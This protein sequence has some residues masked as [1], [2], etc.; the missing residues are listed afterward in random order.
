MQ[1]HD[2]DFGLEVDLIIEASSNAIP[3]RLPIL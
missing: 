3:G 1:S 2:L